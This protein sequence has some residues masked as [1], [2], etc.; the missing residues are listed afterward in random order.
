MNRRTALSV[1]GALVVATLLSASAL[2]WS[3]V[4]K[5]T[6]LTFSTA[7]RLPGVTLAAGEYQFKQPYTEPASGVV[8]VSSRD[9]KHVYFAA[10]TRETKR[11]AGLPRDGHV[12]FGE[13]EGSSV[14]YVK[15]WFPADQRIGREFAY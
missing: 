1:S 12:V 6:Y 13:T 11:P 8:R 7:I 3:D 5:T 9:G 10:F 14:P 2:A 15:A 4:D